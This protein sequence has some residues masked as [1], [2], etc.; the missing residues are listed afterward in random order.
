M[1]IFVLLHR[2]NGPR[3]RRISIYDRSIQILS[4]L[5]DCSVDVKESTPGNLDVEPWRADGYATSVFRTRF[6]LDLGIGAKL[7]DKSYQQNI[8]QN[9]G[10]PLAFSLI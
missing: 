8:S 6:V 9:N 7:S 4:A 1:K 10:I 3:R 2:R 5:G